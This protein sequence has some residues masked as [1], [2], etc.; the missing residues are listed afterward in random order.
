MKYGVTKSKTKEEKGTRTE[1]KVY[2]LVSKSKIKQHKLCDKRWER[3]IIIII[4]D[5]Q[6]DVSKTKDGKKNHT[7]NKYYKS[8]RNVSLWKKWRGKNGGKNG[9][10]KTSNI[11]QGQRIKFSR[12]F[13]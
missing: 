9:E 1:K 8:K 12:L 11:K 2:K 7:Q 10:E 6:G 3:L 5:R 4:K 13:A